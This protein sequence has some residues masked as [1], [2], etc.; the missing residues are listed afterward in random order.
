MKFGTLFQ[1][2]ITG[3]NRRRRGGADVRH[4]AERRRR[5]RVPEL[6]RDARLHAAAGRPASRAACLFPALSSLQADTTRFAEAT[7]RALNRVTAVLYPAACPAF[8]GADRSSARLRGVG[9]RGTGGAVLS[10]PVRL[11]RA[12][13]RRS[14]CAPSTA[15]GGLTM[16]SGSTS[17]APSWRGRS[18]SRS[19][20]GSGFVG[21]AV[22]SATLACAGRVVHGDDR[23]APACRSASCRRQCGPARGEPRQ[24]AVLAALVA[25]WIHDLTSLLVAGSVSAA[26]YVVPRRPHRRSRLARRVHGR[27]ANGAPGVRATRLKETWRRFTP[28]QVRDFLRVGHEGREPSLPAQGDRAARGHDASV[29]DVGCGTGVMFELIRERRPQLDYL[30]IDVTAQFVAA[31][32]ERFPADAA[33]FR[34][35]LALRARSAARRVRRGAVPAHPGASARLR[36]R[37]CSACTRAPAASSSSCS[38]CRRVRSG[39]GAKRDERLRAGLLHPHVRRRPLRRPP[40]D[41]PRPAARA[42]PDPSAAGNERSQF[43]VG[44][45]G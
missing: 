27:L 21:F 28:A 1:G 11:H 10:L 34:R 20:C 9:A 42:G 19:S 6:G 33:R 41:R 16:S 44:R 32:R 25:V 8:A 2:S 24:R 18:R 17:R 35:R 43:R 12:A 36:A 31:A 26:A 22:A 23:A 37:R 30:G 4:G 15:W 5:R 7:A 3:R 14:S 13:P 45:S 39:S 38:T 29:L 40:A